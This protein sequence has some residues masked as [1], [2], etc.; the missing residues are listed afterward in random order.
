MFLDEVDYPKS[1]SSMSSYTNRVQL[2]LSKKAGYV[3][4]PVKRES[5][6][7]PINQTRIDNAQ[8][9]RKK[10]LKTIK[11]NYGRAPFFEGTYEMLEA[12]LAEPFE[13][14]SQLNM[15]AITDITN[16]LGWERKILLQSEMETK[17]S[18][19]DLLIEIV[20]KSGGDAYLYGKGA[21]KY[22]EDERFQAQNIKLVEQS[23]VSPEY[24]QALPEFVK[25]L[26]IL[27][28]L[29]FIGPE[30]TANI[31]ANIGASK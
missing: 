29:F 23:F 13:F 6:P 8:P 20:G 26:S 19:T 4:C 1:G 25:G 16:L 7:Q 17:Q 27:D 31:L 3:N 21:G 12:Q 5:G 10:L 15:R 11:I 18:S 2:L 30:D 24:E 28:A 22:Q 14:I 9:W